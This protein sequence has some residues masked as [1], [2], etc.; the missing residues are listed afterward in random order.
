MKKRALMLLLLFFIL[1]GCTSELPIDSITTPEPPL[2][3]TPSD[4]Q[5]FD[6]LFWYY[7]AFTDA[8]VFD[9]LQ[10]YQP[11][12]RI[13]NAKTTILKEDL[14]ETY[15][16]ISHEAV[17]MNYNN[18]YYIHIF[19]Y[20]DVFFKDCDTSSDTFSCYVESWDSFYDI[21][22]DVIKN[23]NALT[24]DV[25]MYYDYDEVKYGFYIHYDFDIVNDKIVI[26][27][28]QIETADLDGL[29]HKV[30]S[31]VY[32]EIR[33]EVSFEITY[34]NQI[35]DIFIYH[36][37]DYLN[38]D[39][40]SYLNSPDD[41]NFY[42]TDSDL[43][44]KQEYGDVGELYEYQS[45]TYFI[46]G[47]K[48]LTY[49]ENQAGYVL[50]YNMMMVDGWDSYE[51]SADGNSVLALNLSDESIFYPTDDT[52]FRTSINQKIMIELIRS[53]TNFNDI[54]VDLTDINLNFSLITKET[55]DSHA[56][57]FM[58]DILS[59]ME[60]YGFVGFETIDFIHY[61]ETF[62]KYRITALNNHN[63][64]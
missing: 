5:S 35:Q 27:A 9:S 48:A 26:D 63:A 45:T 46:D 29:G 4:N 57:T 16:N 37:V 53:E 58:I 62:L 1:V 7:K 51:R 42:Y 64:E 28:A 56:E 31:S 10:I 23:E 25:Q 24:I 54:D 18:I 32:V 20:I 59:V 6:D 2:E 22:T 13:S 8:H 3:P 17:L 33:E 15:E 41:K 40:V 43:G 12:Y 52:W 39:E 61:D 55:I 50:S 30:T 21:N 49:Y 47:I 11:Y 60:T 19:S 44:I 14:I 36:M 38:Q 34:H